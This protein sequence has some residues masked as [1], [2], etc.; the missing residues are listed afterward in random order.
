MKYQITEACIGCGICAQACRAGS[1]PPGGPVAPKPAR[2]EDKP[3]Q[4]DGKKFRINT[5]KCEGCAACVA[6]CPAGAIIA[7]NDTLHWPAHAPKVLDADLA[8][9]GGGGAGLVA[10]VYAASQGKKVVILEKMPFAGGGAKFAADWRIFR[11][12]WQQE[13]GLPDELNRMLLKGMDATQWSLEPDLV[14]N[15]L[16]NTG[17]FFDWFQSLVPDYEFVEGIYAMD[18]GDPQAQRVPFVKP[19]NGR[20]PNGT[21]YVET[22]EAECH[23]RGIPLL[24]RHRVKNLEMADGKVSAVIA[25]SPGGEVKVRCRACVLASGSW[26]RNEKIMKEKFPEF[27][28]LLPHLEPSQHASMAYTGDGIALAEQAGA[29][30][31]YDSFVL[32]CMGPLGMVPSM[33]ASAI[34]ASPLCIWVNLNGKRWM[35]EG[36]MARAGMSGSVSFA[37][38][39]QL[40]LQPGGINY[41][42]FDK[43]MA[44]RIKATLDTDDAPV[45]FFGPMRLGEDYLDELEQLSR[46]ENG[47]T[48]VR[49]DTIEELAQNAGIH[50]E[51]LRETIERYN[52]MCAR[53]ED[54]ELFKPAS[55]LVPFTGGPYYAVQ[56][57]L[58]H[59]GAFGGVKI[60]ANTQAYAKGGGVVEN[61]F[62]PGDF[63]S[64]RFLNSGGVK[65][66]VINDLGWAV[67]SGYTSGAKAVEYLERH[68]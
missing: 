1:I 26:I 44:E 63:A 41:T 14:Y 30:I 18:R 29:L 46:Q 9:I 43:A 6:T 34:S 36:N 48:F 11:S 21:F 13:R 47:R 45:S 28:R 7:E 32:R 50:A 54:A 49:G 20:S 40:S 66:Q 10:A 16:R 39:T 4:R 67:S 31:D 35:N 22:L 25:Q 24:Y 60:N 51:N 59:D 37:M 19:V 58:N 27:W 65:E 42:I 56:G 33:A 68:E 3:I 57:H 52:W 8:V 62:V 5:E 55:Q 38:G 2:P 15:A 61:L 64:G 23:K 17:H 12:K 53:G